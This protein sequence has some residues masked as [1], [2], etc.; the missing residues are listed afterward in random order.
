MFYFLWFINKRFTREISLQFLLLVVGFFGDM[1]PFPTDDVI[2]RRTL[3]EMQQTN[4]RALRRQIP[5]LDAVAMN[6]QLFQSLKRAL[7]HAS[8]RART[9][10]QS[11]HDLG[12]LRNQYRQ[13]VRESSWSPLESET[14]YRRQ[15]DIGKRL[16]SRHGVRWFRSK[17]VKELRR[18]RGCPPAR[19]CRLVCDAASTHRARDTSRAR[20]TS[21]RANAES[22]R[23]TGDG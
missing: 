6:A 3:N 21:P 10:I 13:L 19:S 23:R 22:Y 17:C 15:H 9:E 8:V 18:R 14:Y 4:Q 5:A 11:A 20:A 2:L 7:R 16:S 1:H 12:Q